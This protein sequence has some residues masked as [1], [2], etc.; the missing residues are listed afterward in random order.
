MEK[1]T[2]TSWLM[3]ILGIIIIIV[4][5]IMNV[6]PAPLATTIMAQTGWD[7]GAVGKFVSVISLMV[8]IF[9][10]VGS[11]LQDRLGIKLTAF[12]GMA[13]ACI[14]GILHFFAGDSYT[15]NILE[16]LLVGAGKGICVN[17]PAAIIPL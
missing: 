6:M 8:G 2:K 7:V 17:V 1:A 16:R 5:A 9:C 11:S 13:F 14:G 15:L 12:I 3:F 10:F 4:C